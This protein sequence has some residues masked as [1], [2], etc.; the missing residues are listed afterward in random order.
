ML[1]VQIECCLFHL[2][3]TKYQSA[4]QNEWLSQRDSCKICLLVLRS[5]KS[6][7]HLLADMASEQYS[8][9]FSSVYNEL[10]KICYHQTKH[11]LQCPVVKQKICGFGNVNDNMCLHV[12]KNNNDNYFDNLKNSSSSKKTQIY[13]HSSKSSSSFFFFTL[14]GN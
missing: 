2:S 11:P 14:A 1:C 9:I 8:F 4:S 3:F 6:K 13:L 5:N 10:L 12:K 7:H